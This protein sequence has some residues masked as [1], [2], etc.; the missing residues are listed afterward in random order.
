M[1]VLKFNGVPVCEPHS[2][3]LAC[4]IEAYERQ[5]VVTS[6]YG[7]ELATGFTITE[8]KPTNGEQS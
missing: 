4:V 7:V 8:V 5:A 6:R 2:T 1:H 3:H